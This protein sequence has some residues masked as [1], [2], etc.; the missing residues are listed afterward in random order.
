MAEPQTR[1]VELPKPGF[2]MLVRMFTDNLQS[3][4]DPGAIR[5]DLGQKHP[6]ADELKIVRMF[7]DDVREGVEIYSSSDDGAT[8]VR[9]FIPMRWVRMIKEGMPLEVF[10][11]EM[12]RSEEGPDDD[13]EDDNDVDLEAPD[14]NA[15][16]SARVTH[17]PGPAP[18]GQA[19]S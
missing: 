15:P 18:N 5:W 8:G 10:I 13:D 17:D 12:R 9:D 16:E 3:T 4:N 7:V 2:P 19:T 6:L 1:F 11:D 14:D